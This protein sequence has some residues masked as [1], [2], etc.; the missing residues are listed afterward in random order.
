MPENDPDQ[1]TTGAGSEAADAGQRHHRAVR[2]FVVRAGRMT[3]AQDRA[4]RELWPAIGV[5]D[6]D[7]PIDFDAL[8]GRRAPRTVEIGFGLWGV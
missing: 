7:E 5:T 1:E 4:W 6:C 3:V 8:F 2:S